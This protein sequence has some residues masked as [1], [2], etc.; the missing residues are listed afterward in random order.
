MS[1]AIPELWG[2]AG[3]IPKKVPKAKLLRTVGRERRVRSVLALL[4]FRSDFSVALRSDAELTE[5]KGKD[6][7]AAA[8]N[9]KPANIRRFERMVEF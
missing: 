3:G 7:A 1:A 4:T 8:I 5:Y 2:G 9:K 6:A